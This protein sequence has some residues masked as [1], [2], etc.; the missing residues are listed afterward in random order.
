MDTKECKYC[1]EQIAKDAKRCP[2]CGGKFGMPVWAKILIILVIIFGCLMG[3]VGG[4]VGIFATAVKETENDYN[5]NSITAE[6]INEEI[7]TTFKINEPFEN[8]YEKIIMTEVN[9]NF[10]DYSRYSEPTEGYKYVM[11]KFEVENVNSGND[12]LYVSSYSFNADADGIAV[13]NTYV[14]NDQYKSLSATLGKGKK[15]I[16]YIFYEVPVSAQKITITYN[17]NFWID[18]NAI[19]FIVQE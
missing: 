18:G 5:N 14:G 8:K 2:K 19:E 9:T 4:C 13:D 17:P 12:E 1:K 3:C 6:E 10:T 16:G 11:V 15:A 7:K